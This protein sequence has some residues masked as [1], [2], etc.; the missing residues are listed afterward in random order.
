MPPEP[1]DTYL[2]VQRKWK[3]ES[4]EFTPWLAKHLHIL[5]KALGM[6]L[7]LERTEA[8]AGPFSCDILATELDTRV[9]VAIENQLKLSDHDH[10]GKLLTYS[11]VLGARV[12]V[13]VTP[14]FT[15]EHAEALHIL[16]QWTHGDVQFY[17]VKLLL[18][19][20][21][22]TDAE[23]LLQPVVTPSRWDKA[24][25]QPQRAISPLK[26]QY[27]AFYGPLVD[28]LLPLGFSEKVTQHYDPSGR[29]F[30][31]SIN[32]SMG[33]ATT[34]EERGFAW[35][36]LHLQADDNALTKRIFDKLKQDKKAIEASIGLGPEI[37]WHW[38]RKNQYKY[39]SIN[40]RRAGT[41]LDSPDK[42]DETRTWMIDV[43]RRFKCVFDPRLTAVLGELKGHYASTVFCSSDPSPRE[44]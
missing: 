18:H 14:A 27:D 29:I 15:Y 13:W 5:G 38:Y 23:P 31:S 11:A 10:L 36:G 35:V 6:N 12:A 2:D 40:A 21:G 1:H 41:I 33:Y 22:D 7:Q 24:L 4:A 42:L 20:V 39:S 9:R 26:Q 30:P 19:A 17:G 3:D 16:N 25:T 34:L 43:L 8:Q 28:Q 37:T 44:I 32:S